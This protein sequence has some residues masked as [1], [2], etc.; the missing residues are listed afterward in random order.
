MGHW[1]EGFI[2][3]LVSRELIR[4][5]EDNT[6]RPEAP[7]TRAQYA[8]ILAKAFDGA[9]K[10]PATNFSDV[11]GNFWAAAAIQKVIQMGFM[12][13]FPDGTF[14]PNQNLTR[15]QA[16]VAL[17]NGLGL[18]GGVLDSLGVYGDRAQIPSYATSEVA[19]ATQR[20][21]VVNYPNARQ[22]QPMRDI[23]RAEVVALIYQALVALNRAP[24][25]A[26]PYIVTADV[27]TTGAFIDIQGHWAANFILGLAN[28]N[29][30]RGF[31]DGSFRP[32]TSINRAQYAAIIAKAFNP[33]AKRDGIN[34]PDVPATYWAKAAIDQAYRS[35]FISGFPDGSF[36]PDVNVLRLQI[37]LSLVSGLGLPAA[38]VSLLNTYTDL[39]KIPQNARSAIAIATQQGLVVNYPDVRQINPIREATREEVSAMVYQAMVRAGKAPP[40]NS[41]Y[42]VVV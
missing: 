29:L 33:P 34:F 2:Q 27:P 16:I 26:S 20:R 17:V 19:T 15:V 28:Q 3:G 7:L 10:K 36:K 25:I 12:A 38:D 22:L 9:L 1:A 21:I 8:A 39:D 5:F 37:L 14:R 41:P 13:G 23:T 11:P 30:I 32:D 42:I 35:G 6:F 24:A 40:L 4:G 18:A 31:E